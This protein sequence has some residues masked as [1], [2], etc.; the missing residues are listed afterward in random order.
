[1]GNLSGW[2]RMRKFRVVMVSEPEDTRS[3]TVRS[4][5]KELEA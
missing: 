3:S 1:M 5:E 4:A 2:Y